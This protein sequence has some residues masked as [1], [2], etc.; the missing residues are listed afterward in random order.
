[1][2]QNKWKITYNG[3]HIGYDFAETE[4]DMLAEIARRNPNHDPAKFKVEFHKREA[5]K[6]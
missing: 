5:R 2:E 6:D 3:K 1:M 4:A